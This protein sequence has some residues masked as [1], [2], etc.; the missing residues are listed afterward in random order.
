[1]N[2]WKPAWTENS[3]QR[4]PEHPRIIGEPRGRGRSPAPALRAL[5]GRRVGGA[6]WSPAG[7]A[8]LAAAGC[9]ATYLRLHRALTGSRDGLSPIAVPPGRVGSAGPRRS[10]RRMPVRWRRPPGSMGRLPVIRRDGIRFDVDGPR[11]AF[12]VGVVDRWADR[13]IART[14]GSGAARCPCTGRRRA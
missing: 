5:A 14:V 2:A 12:D 3:G 1:M 13:V 11:P 9:T 6:G 7:H 10:D 4:E 8:T